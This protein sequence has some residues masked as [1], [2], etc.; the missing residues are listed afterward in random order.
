MRNWIAADEDMIIPIIAIICTIGLP[1]L[2]LLVKVL[3]KHQQQMLS[4]MNRQSNVDENLKQDIQAL[5]SQIQDMKHTLMDH[6]MSLDR[7]VEHLGRRVDAMEQGQ[8]E[9]LGH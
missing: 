6:A 7:N 4:L 1:M 5:S 8:S 2:I 9:R 3:S